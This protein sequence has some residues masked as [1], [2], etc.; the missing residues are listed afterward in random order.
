MKTYR[1]IFL[2]YKTQFSHLSHDRLLHL[3]HGL[4][5]ALFSGVFHHHSFLSIRN[6]CS[7]ETIDNLL[8][9]ADIFGYCKL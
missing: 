1:G 8:E 7:I 4:F 6:N 9:V 5:Y 2:Y 3:T